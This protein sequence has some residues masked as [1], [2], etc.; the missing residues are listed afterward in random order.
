MV[1][2]RATIS[3]PNETVEGEIFPLSYACKINVEAASLDNPYFHVH[4]AEALRYLEY[5]RAQFLK[6]LGLPLETFIERGLL[7]MVSQ[8]SASYLREIR[9][10]EHAITVDSCELS[11]KGCRLVQRVVNSKQKDCIVADV[12]LVFVDRNARRAVPIPVY[13]VEAM[14]SSKRT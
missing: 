5:G 6:E 11:R 10:G 12:S 3:R 9:G 4:H 13:F 7:I 2:I 14:K 1:D 8:V